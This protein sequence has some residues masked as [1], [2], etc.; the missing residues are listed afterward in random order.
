MADPGRRDKLLTVLRVL[1]VLIAVRSLMNV[2]KP[3]GTG[4]GLVFFGFLLNG[5]VM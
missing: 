3:F 1:A 5:P 2:G 4:S